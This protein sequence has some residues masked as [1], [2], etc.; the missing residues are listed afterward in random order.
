MPNGCKCTARN[1]VWQVDDGWWNADSGACQHSRPGFAS[2]AD[3]MVLLTDLLCVYRQCLQMLYLVTW[4]E[5]RW[6]RWLCSRHGLAN[7][8]RRW[9][10]IVCCRSSAATCISSEWLAIVTL[11]TPMLAQYWPWPPACRS[12]SP[13]R[14]SIETAE[15]IVPVFISDAF[16]NLPLH[17]VVQKLGYLQN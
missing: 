1:A 15:C 4:W 5:V 17:Y 16:F 11:T 8:R 6:V 7:T 12:V 3:T 2:P 9:K 13:S 14:N 10:T